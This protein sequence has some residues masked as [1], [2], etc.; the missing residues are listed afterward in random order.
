MQCLYQIYKGICKKNLK[1]PFC[2]SI[3]K[4]IVFQLKQVYKLF[5]SFM[6]SFFSFKA[7]IYLFID[8]VFSNL[9]ISVKITFDF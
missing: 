7:N 8:D 2:F 5:G 6:T 9:L 3:L 4:Y 1:S